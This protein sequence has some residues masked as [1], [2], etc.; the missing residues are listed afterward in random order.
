MLRSKAFMKKTRKGNVVRVV[1]E[2]YLR[3]DIVCSVEG[4][5]RCDFNADTT[6]L[7]ANNKFV[8]HHPV[9]SNSPRQTEQFPVPA[10]IVPDTNVLVNQI[11]IL[12]HSAIKNVIILQTCLDELKHLSMPTYHRLRTVVGD[13][14]RRFYV[15]SN[16]HHRE[17]YVERLKDE[18]P[19]DRNDRAI[20]RAVQWYKQHLGSA[21]RFPTPIEVVMLTDDA[22]NRRRADQDHIANSSV[23]RYL[24][25]FVDYPELLDMVAQV[26]IDNNADRKTQY[27]EH[28]TKLQ[29]QAGLKTQKYIQGTL[30]ISHH[31]FLEGS[32]H[33]AVDG[34]D[35][36]IAIQGRAHLNRAVHGD[37]VVVELLPKDEWQRTPTEIRMDT[38]ADD[39]DEEEDDDDEN[40]NKNKANS[41]STAKKPKST[42]AAQPAS[43]PEASELAAMP[44]QPTGKVVG[45]LRRNWRPYCG[46]LDPKSLRIHGQSSAAQ[47]VLFLPMD[48]RVPKIKVRTRQA[49][50]LMGQRVVVNID[51]WPRDSRL[52]LG[53]FVKALGSAGDRSTETEV[54]LM[55][56]DVPYQEFSKQVLADLPTE[57]DSWVVLEDQHVLNSGRQDFR[58]LNVCSID[59]PGCTDIDDAL[60]CHPLPNGNFSVGVHIAD[61]THFLKPNTAMDREA[62]NRCTTVY[63]VDRRIDMLPPLLGTNLCSLHSNVDRLAFSCVW[64]LDSEANIVDVTFTKSV[65]RSRHSFTYDEAQARID[66][67]TLTDSITVGVR[68]LNQ[69][70][71]KLRARRMHNG[72]LTLASPEVRFSLEND[73]QD[74]VDVEMKALKETNAL[75]EEFMLLANISVAK[76][77]YE[78]FPETSMLRRH[79]TPPP[80]NFEGLARQLAANGFELRFD[81]SLELSRSLDNADKSG[82]PYFNQLVRIMTTRCMMQAVYFSSGT[83]AEPE[84]HH[85]GLAS[86]IYTHF[87]SPIRRFADVLVHRLLDAA[88][89]PATTAYNPM[90]TDKN[91]MQ[92]QADTLNYRNRMAQ[93]AARSSV[94]LYTHLFFRHKVV[95][96][97]AHVFRVLK[98]GFSVLVPRYGIEGFIYASTKASAGKSGD[99]KEILVYD[100][101]RDA[102]VNEDTGIVIKVFDKVKVQIAVDKETWDPHSHSFVKQQVPKPAGPKSLATTT[103]NGKSDGAGSTD[104]LDLK[105]EE[106]PTLREKMQMQL[107]E[108]FI[109]GLSFAETTA[110]PE[111]AALPSPPSLEAPGKAGSQGASASSASGD[112]PQVKKRKL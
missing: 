55:E 95:V 66:D 112:H 108:P 77:I 31:N 57:G 9:L 58:N 3:D 101:T 102:L 62:A 78:A 88:I 40:H 67:K 10:L 64:E 61:V 53:H 96:E 2:H 110:E 82:D 29:C 81:S 65:I 13:P 35:R 79:P 56:H 11:D 99:R 106:P 24:Q 41:H 4:C 59:P 45:I 32:I 33:G 50:Q 6:G 100:A 48:S 75:V 93:Q 73:S 25:D 68:Q 60:H 109:P 97:D 83:L 69:L 51:S 19:N 103:D 71:K 98:N 44:A 26:T 92:E 74:P 86:P 90:L 63:L 38:T 54:L 49:H 47:G 22:D 5:Q 87:T 30:N 17:T 37:V 76:R 105:N 104:N 7:S 70:A 52:P 18:S 46:H 94:E 1:K 21:S 15:F 42:G 20:R 14:D 39:D 27:P 8:V 16:E 12:E 89:S 34:E 84:F 28:L 111:S 72:A 36:T 80:S 43:A 107:V 91:K 85:Y 23:A